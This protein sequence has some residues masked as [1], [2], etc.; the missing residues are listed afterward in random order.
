[1]LQIPSQRR[2]RK[3]VTLSISVQSPSGYLLSIASIWVQ[4]LGPLPLWWTILRLMLGEWYPV[5]HALML[6]SE[7]FHTFCPRSSM[8][9]FCRFSHA[10]AQKHH[11][12]HEKKSPD[13]SSKPRQWP[14]QGQSTHLLSARHLACA[15]ASELFFNF[16]TWM[17]ARNCF[18]MRSKKVPVRLQPS[19]S[20]LPP[21]YRWRDFFCA[22]ADQARSIVGHLNSWSVEE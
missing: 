19:G 22:I 13:D 15:S 5:V 12:H 10:V 4:T 21:A 18:E 9:R 8:S 1:M 7:I 16:P 20:I 2:W 3:N 14:S 11:F 17:E 6:Q